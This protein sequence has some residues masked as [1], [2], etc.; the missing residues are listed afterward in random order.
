MAFKVVAKKRQKAVQT[1]ISRDLVKEVAY[2]NRTSYIVDITRF[3]GS[4]NNPLD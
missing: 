3:G 2:F 1:P 4:D